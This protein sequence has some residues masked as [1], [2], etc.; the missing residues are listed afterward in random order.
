MAI[1][2]RISGETYERLALSEPDRKWELRDG[3]LREKPAMTS[4]HNWLEVK[5]GYLLMSQLDWSIFQVR[6]DAG[7]VRRPEATYFIPDVFVIPTSLVTPLLDLQ[8]VLEVY[9]QPLPLVVEVWSRSTG[10]YDVEEKLR[11]Y[12]NRGDQEIWQ[13]HPYERTL[14]TWRRL[15]NGSYEEAVYS[16]GVVH[17]IALP[18]IVIDL[19]ALFDN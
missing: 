13:I 18:G 4:A 10:D 1:E 6:V 15:P 9:D 17:P 8:D 5:L 3:V 16:E 14:T 2:T 12:R 11:V 7:R 19:A